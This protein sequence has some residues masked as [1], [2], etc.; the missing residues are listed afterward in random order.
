[1]KDAKRDIVDH[2]AQDQ[3]SFAALRTDIAGLGDRLSKRIDE[4][5]TRMDHMRD[6]LQ[7]QIDQFTRDKIMAE[8]KAQGLA[9][10]KNID[11]Q[12]KAQAAE[13]AKPNPWAIA[14]V[15]VIIAVLLTLICTWL[16]RDKIQGPTQDIRTTT[17]TQVPLAAVP[18]PGA[19]TPAAQPSPPTVPAPP[20]QDTVQP[21]TN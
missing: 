6:G 13:E 20:A 14:I 17:T 19:P 4:M 11:A 15:P 9:E 18:P 21:S 7:S 10:A 8:G 12:V 3:Q 16:I 2:K 5:G 1:M